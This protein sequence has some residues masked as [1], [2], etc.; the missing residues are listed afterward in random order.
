[1]G[2][3][4]RDVNKEKVCVYRQL[5]LGEVPG[6]LP[7]GTPV[8]VMNDPG[9]LDQ[10]ITEKAKRGATF[11]SA[12]DICY[13]QPCREVDNCELVIEDQVSHVVVA[14]MNVKVP[15]RLYGIGRDVDGALIIN[16]DLNLV[17]DRPTHRLDQPS[18]ALADGGT[19]IKSK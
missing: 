16:E 1:M 2:H 15:A 4:M 11:E 12:P 3:M 19:D 5:Q 10:E 18:Q 14:S 17:L 13:L 7:Y 8:L 9:R 6:K